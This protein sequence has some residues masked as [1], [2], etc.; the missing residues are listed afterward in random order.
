MPGIDFSVFS[1]VNETNK[2]TSTSKGGGY[3]G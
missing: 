1:V 2:K 3:A